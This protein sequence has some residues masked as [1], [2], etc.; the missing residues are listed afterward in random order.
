MK[1]SILLPDLAGGGA[2]RVKLCL[3]QEWL[4]QG[5]EVEFVLLRKEGALLPLVPKG[6]TIH[7]LN[8]KRLRSS[9]KPL[10]TYLRENQPS[11]LLAAMWPLTVIA[12][13]AHRLAGRPG[14]LV[15]SDHAALS[16]LPEA[17]GWRKRL[18]LRA[19]IALTYPL[20]DK[21]VAVSNGV[22]DNLARLGW[23]DRQGITVIYNPA[24][25]GFL[26][27]CNHV[28]DLWEPLPGKRVIS[29]GT[30]KS[31]KDHAL[32]IRAFSLVRKKINASLVILG[33]GSLRPNLEQLISKLDLCDVV[34]LPGFVLDPYPW[35]RE[36]DLFVLSSQY[37]GFGNVI[38]EAMECGLPVVSTDCEAGPS[39]ILNGGQ[40][41]KLVPVGDVVA[42]A[43]AM[44]EVLSEP[45][46]PAQQKVRAAE[47]SVERAAQAYLKLLDPMKTQYGN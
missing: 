14:R 31:Q 36:A 41:G 34:K 19:S 44:L 13:L 32:L 46:S 24:A 2:E 18:V 43:E 20:A 6:A 15:V 21:R 10:V 4:L 29:V 33:E 28:P 12:I 17:Q 40:F 25:R 5:Y 22:A 35:Y 16:Q 47:F 30:L 3:A 1:I 11:A 7:S 45:P 38:V 8:C 42:L 23:L 27:S 39:E 37:E 9:I 26:Q